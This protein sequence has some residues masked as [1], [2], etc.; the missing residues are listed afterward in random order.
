LEVG[1][2]VLLVPLDPAGNHG[3]EDVQDHRVPRG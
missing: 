1:D 2:D 3:D